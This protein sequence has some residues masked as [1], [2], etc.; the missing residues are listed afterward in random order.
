[1]KMAKIWYF[2]RTFQFLPDS[3]M[4]KELFLGSTDF[5]V[6][7]FK[8]PQISKHFST[9][10]I[11]FIV[12]LWT[13]S[14]DARY[15]CVFKWKRIRHVPPTAICL[16]EKSDTEAK[17]NACAL[18]FGSPRKNTKRFVCRNVSTCRSFSSS[19][20]ELFHQEHYVVNL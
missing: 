7:I 19:K 8:I 16:S 13:G 4:L 9:M 18:D 2:W 12:A 20:L 1:M 17:G 5:T 10:L 3:F 15:H 14:E 11:I 6:A